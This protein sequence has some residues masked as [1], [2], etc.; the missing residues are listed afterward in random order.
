MPATLDAESK[1]LW[2]LRVSGTLKRSEFATTQAEAARKIDTGSK[3]K[4]LVILEDFDGWERGA[5]WNDLD[6][7]VSHSGAISK[8]AV[9]AEPQWETAALAFA[10]AGVRGAPVQ[11]FKLAELDAARAWIAE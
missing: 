8:I 5:D 4:L 3:P 1:D 7:L 9:V 11:F 10:G 2:V 6:F